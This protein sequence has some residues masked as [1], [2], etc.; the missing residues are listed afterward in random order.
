[1]FKT[2]IENLAN[3]KTKTEAMTNAEVVRREFM[4]LDRPSDTLD[5]DNQLVES[6]LE[7]FVKGFDY[8]TVDPMLKNN[9]LMLRMIAQF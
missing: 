2:A 8:P 5:V 1:M 4:K 6:T 9:L 7:M 3:S